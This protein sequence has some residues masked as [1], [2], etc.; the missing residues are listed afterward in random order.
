MCGRG[1]TWDLVVSLQLL[2]LG[3]ECLGHVGARGL[4]EAGQDWAVDGVLAESW[5]G[6][7]VLWVFAEETARAGHRPGIIHRPAPDA[8][9]PAG[10]LQPR[11]GRGP[12]PSGQQAC[13]WGADPSQ[14]GRGRGGMGIVTEVTVFHDNGLIAGSSRTLATLWT[15][16]HQALLSM[17]FFPGKNFG[18]D[19]YF[20]LQGIF[21]RPMPRPPSKARSLLYPS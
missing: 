13:E 2:L 3:T 18:V 21:P 6:V 1:F 16:A 5:S 12:E 7:T 8:A 4:E 10:R 15:V 11:Q 14:L 9:R 19:Y 17:E 20:L